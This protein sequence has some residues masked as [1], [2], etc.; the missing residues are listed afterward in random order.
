MAQLQRKAIAPRLPLTELLTR[1]DGEA[2]MAI[3]RLMELTEFQLQTTRED[4]RMLTKPILQSL[5]PAPLG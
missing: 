5:R 1:Q 3:A 2:R 4:S